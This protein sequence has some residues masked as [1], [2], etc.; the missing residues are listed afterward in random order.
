MKN[1]IYQRKEG[2]DK[3]PP[4]Q[5]HSQL[6]EQNEESDLKKM[7]LF[8]H[9]FKNEEV[10]LWLKSLFENYNYP[11]IQKCIELYENYKNSKN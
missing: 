10:I 3:F 1:Y 2:C 4:S 5:D 6:R 7:L 11:N 8:E 9:I